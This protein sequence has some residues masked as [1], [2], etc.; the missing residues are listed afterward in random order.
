MTR[1]PKHTSLPWFQKVIATAIVLFVYAVPLQATRY[2][3]C[4]AS[5][6]KRRNAVRLRAKLEDKKLGTRIERAVVRG[7]TFYRV[8]YRYA[9][10][11][12]RTPLEFIRVLKSE[13]QYRPLTFRSA[14]VFAK[15]TADDPPFDR[16]PLSRRQTAKRSIPRA[17]VRRK[18][19]PVPKKAKP[20]AADTRKQTEQPRDKKASS[21]P[22]A[23]P[24][25]NVP[26]NIAA[27]P[28]TH[29]P[30]PI[31]TSPEQ[32]AYAYIF[33]EAEDADKVHPSMDIAYDK[34]ASE[35]RYITIREDSG[36]AWAVNATGSAT[37]TLTI[38]KDGKYAFWGR[39][40]WEHG[41]SSLF[42]FD[43]DRRITSIP[44]S[45]PPRMLCGMRNWK[46]R[47]IY[48]GKTAT[49]HTWHWMASHVFQ[50]K[51]GKHTITIKNCDDGS[52]LDAFLLTNDMDYRPTGKTPIIMNR[53]FTERDPYGWVLPAG[54]SISGGVLEKSSRGDSKPASLQSVI[55]G[56]FF[57]AL[58]GKFRDAAVIL[59]SSSGEAPVRLITRPDQ[60]I[61]VPEN[62]SSHT[63]RDRSA[64]GSV[65]DGKTSVRLFF[66]N[67]S[68][69][70]ERNGLL[71]SRHR[72]KLDFPVRVEID[73]GRGDAL[74]S[75]N[76][77]T[78]EPIH[79]GFTSYFTSAVFQFY[80]D[81]NWRVQKKKGITPPRKGEGVL[82]FGDP[83][84]HNLQLS[85][86]IQPRRDKPLAAALCYRDR[87]NHY[88]VRM[89]DGHMK[90][91]YM[92]NGRETVLDDRAVRYDTA[93]YHRVTINKY[94]DIITVYLDG[95][96]VLH[97][98]HHGFFSGRT[99]FLSANG[100]N[101]FIDDLEVWGWDQPAPSDHDRVLYFE[102]PRARVIHSVMD[103]TG[104]T[105]GFH[106]GD[107]HHKRREDQ[108]REI[109]RAL[110]RQVRD[111][112]KIIDFQWA[113]F[114][115]FFGGYFG[116]GK[117]NGYLY[118]ARRSSPGEFLWSLRN[119]F[120][121]FT[122]QMDLISTY[123]PFTVYLVDC[124][125]TPFNGQWAAV[126]LTADHTIETAGPLTEARRFK[127]S[128]SDLSDLGTL[129]IVKTDT[130]L[131][132]HLNNT[133]IGRTSFRGKGRFLRPGVRS[134]EA[135]QR[136]D[137]VQAYLKPDL[138][139]NFQMSMAHKLAL[140]DWVIACDNTSLRGGYYSFLRFEKKQGQVEIVT[141]RAFRGNLTL[142]TMIHKDDSPVTLF[143]RPSQG[144][145]LAFIL[146]ENGGQLLLGGDDGSAIIYQGFN[147]K[148]HSHHTVWLSV[149]GRSLR[150]FLS[151]NA[152]NQ[153]PVLQRSFDVTRLGTFRLGFKGD[154]RIFIRSISIWGE[155]TDDEYSD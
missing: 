54:W 11:N 152:G 16:R 48:F 36:S 84:W 144:D 10:D 83:W 22:A 147:K 104:A 124:G 96:Q 120:G 95:R 2:Y 114:G 134:T 102:R 100:G 50:L 91:L 76:T 53:Y 93:R 138:R 136:F 7:R 73:L 127:L 65:Y 85:F 49:Y 135:G 123:A 47:R 75:V 140:S 86:M 13:G 58:K 98:D 79:Y 130:S 33:M 119:L 112:A 72:L 111:R 27:V 117:R 97:A 19:S 5:F 78:I 131:A 116:L 35:G 80:T 15:Q 128:G 26:V 64:P 29:P 44:T 12:K 121:D 52:S 126:K 105:G 133:L 90:L 30:K 63:D 38:P 137:N 92:R 150:L 143:L 66:K 89:G 122:Y 142:R 108:L 25:I 70:Y 141:K 146:R 88:A 51:K 113:T 82:L 60:L 17:A 62:G 109:T 18:T 31:V 3:L 106:P 74:E 129:K 61:V 67:D 101:G 20:A 149:S 32:S 68:V 1:Y 132:V 118:T 8:I 45:L 115:D 94:N 55:R 154:K 125:Q 99:A 41:C 57:L 71:M 151:D 56:D 9:Y 23:L 77:V 145:G 21:K 110:G 153:R 69:I 14:W 37:Y 43:I 81:H 4:F 87:K 59:H 103:H 46:R 34:T 107:Y 28:R 155:E 6:V 39:V 42:G 40:L 148:R 24:T 139:Y